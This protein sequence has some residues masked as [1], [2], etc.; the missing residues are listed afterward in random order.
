MLPPSELKENFDKA[1][2]LVTMH[3]AAIMTNR[4]LSL[5]A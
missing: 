5:F 1:E 2:V 4:P 3:L